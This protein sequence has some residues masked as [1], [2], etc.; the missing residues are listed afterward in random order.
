MFRVDRN[1]GNFDHY[2]GTV[3]WFANTPCTHLV[4]DGKRHLVFPEKKFCCKC[5]TVGC[6]V[7]KPTWFQ[8]GSAQGR[9][10]VN[11]TEAYKYTVAGVQNNYYYET[12]ASKPKR[13]YQHPDSDMVWDSGYTESSIDPKVF[14]LPTDMGDCEQSCGMFTFCKLVGG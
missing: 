2:C 7:V 10:D 3:Y 11:G 13:L 1:N 6:G 5:C 9:E 4:R 12:A 14:E 8:G